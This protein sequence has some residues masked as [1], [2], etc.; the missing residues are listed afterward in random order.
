MTQ[1]KNVTK[2]KPNILTIL[3]FLKGFIVKCFSLVCFHYNIL[4]L[5]K[6]P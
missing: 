3:V 4:A 2:L 6:I 1:K 5:K